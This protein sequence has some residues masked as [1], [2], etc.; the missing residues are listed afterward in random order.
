MP[1][2]S[3]TRSTVPPAQP[4]ETISSYRARV[5]QSEYVTSLGTAPFLKTL[6][7]AI[8]GV[9]PALVS[10]RVVAGSGYEI[11][12][13]GSGDP[14]LIAYAILQA[15]PDIAL[16]VGSTLG[17]AN[18]TAANPGVVTTT[19]NHGYT[20]GQ[21]VTVTGVAP[22]GYN[23]SYTITVID[24]KTFSVGAS[25][26]SLAAYGS[27]GVITP[28]FRNQ[29]IT[30]NYYPDSYTIPFVTPP[31]QAVTMA[32]IWNTSSLNFVSTSAIATLASA[33][34]AGYIN[35]L[36]VGA[37]INVD[38]MVSTF[39]TA[40]AP[41]L[42]AGLISSLTFSVTINGIATTPGSGTVLISGDPESYFATTPASIVVEQA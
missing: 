20:T 37:P 16:L 38:V 18:F 28:N 40:V 8:P 35:G 15:I 12:V 17:V 11:L 10:V 5:L 24:E 33:A 23:G 39:Q 22:G 32:V 4:A 42:Q 6:L 14:Y 3:P 27:G 31:S 36:P 9:N 29:A 7:G 19:L 26:A 2:R 21:V 30:L 25:T 1:S 34:L 13:G 41:I